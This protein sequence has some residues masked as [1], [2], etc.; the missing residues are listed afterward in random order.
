[1]IDPGRPF[2]RSLQALV[3]SLETRIRDGVEQPAQVEFVF[4][5]GEPML[6]SPAAAQCVA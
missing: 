4:G 6:E 3:E 5:A 1:M 2:Q